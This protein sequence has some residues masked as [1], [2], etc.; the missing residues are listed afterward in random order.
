MTAPTAAAVDTIAA[1]SDPAVRNQKITQCYHDLSAV[2]AE[3]TGPCANW[4][5]IATW[6]SQQAG[7]T[8]RGHDLRNKLAQVLEKDPLIS[9]LVQWIAWFAQQAGIR[10]PLEELRNTVVGK[11]AGRAA[12]VSADAVGRGNKKVFE[13]IGREFA[14]FA[15]EC[16]PDKEHRSFKTRAFCESLRDGEP[17]NGQAHL[18][19]AF[20]LYYNSFFEPDEKR[21][22]ELRFLANIEVGFHEQTRLQPE[23]AEA[24]NAGQVRPDE[25]LEALSSLLSQRA[26]FWRRLL[27]AARSLVG[28]HGPLNKKA[29]ELAALLS[30]RMR[31]VLT[32]H[33]MTLTLPPN[34]CLQLGTDLQMPYPE[35]LRQID[36][37]ELAAFLSRVDP[38]KNSLTETGATDWADLPERM[39]YIADL[40]RCC[41][42]DEHLFEPVYFNSE[43][44]SVKF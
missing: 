1:I 7:E 9:E 2:M 17:P 37:P 39:H 25:L 34:R 41:H 29:E 5:T 22:A 8:I 6:A 27:F 13:E 12:N 28:S 32:E 11:W 30:Q 24:L 43:V 21:A 10:V 18:K 36:N 3:R 23:I 33:L 35:L 19:T 20:A 14:R 15:S 4:C 16:L 31:R 26:G 38:T 42:Q 40:F 44:S